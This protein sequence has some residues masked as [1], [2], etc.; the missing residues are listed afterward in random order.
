MLFHYVPQWWSLLVCW[1]RFETRNTIEVSSLMFNVPTQFQLFICHR[2]TP[3]QFPS[4]QNIHLI[5]AILEENPKW[6]INL[7]NCK[8]RERNEPVKSNDCITCQN[9][10]NKFLLSFWGQQRSLQNGSINEFSKYFW[11][12]Y[13]IFNMSWERTFTQ[14]VMS[15]PF[16]FINALY[17][18]G[19]RWKTH[20]RARK[21]RKITQWS[22]LVREFVPYERD[23]H[24]QGPRIIFLSKYNTSSK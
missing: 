23:F 15:S 7:T 11:K 3:I 24:T 5:G 19:Q 14:K 9:P 4:A 21:E 10:F 20:D 13:L 8:K 18:A 2:N 16:L 12:D 17:H 22:F 6:V 1:K